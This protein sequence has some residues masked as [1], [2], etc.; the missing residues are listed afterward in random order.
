MCEPDSSLGPEERLGKSG[1]SLILAYDE[2]RIERTWSELGP[3]L[4]RAWA[5]RAPVT[6]SDKPVR[7]WDEAGPS[8]G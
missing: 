6:R 4:S 5:K 1:V 2:S 7:A 8:L 3:R